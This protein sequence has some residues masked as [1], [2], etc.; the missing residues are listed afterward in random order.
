MVWAEQ[1]YVVVQPDYTRLSG[2]KCPDVPRKLPFPV[3]CYHHL[4][5]LITGES[6]FFAMR[7]A[8]NLD[9]CMRDVKTRAPCIDLSKII[10]V[11]AGFGAYVINW[12]NTYNDTYRINVSS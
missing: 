9:Q 7:I 2:F 3:I 10:A 12:I 11:G 8:K 5:K 6:E 1:G 4:L